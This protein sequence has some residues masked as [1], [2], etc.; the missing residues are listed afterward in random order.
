MHPFPLHSAL[1]RELIWWPAAARRGRAGLSQHTAHQ[2]PREGEPHGGHLGGQ[3][4]SSLQGTKDQSLKMKKDAAWALSYFAAATGIVGT[5]CPKCHLQN[6]YGRAWVSSDHYSPGVSGLLWLTL[7]T[8]WAF[9][10]GLTFGAAPTG[11]TI[12]MGLFVSGIHPVCADTRVT[13]Q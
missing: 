11:G 2:V 7:I 4:A 8:F 5:V 10:R 9:L 1:N 12:R 13:T 3:D 6:S